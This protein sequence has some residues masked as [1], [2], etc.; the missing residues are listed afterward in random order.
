[1]E[2][3]RQNYISNLHNYLK[4]NEKKV[5]TYS[6]GS[7]IVTLFATQQSICQETRGTWNY[8][9]ELTLS[10]TSFHRITSESCENEY[11]KYIM[12]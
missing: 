9:V 3:E 12:R 6:N 4:K 11:I 7:I 5:K 8:G 2:D 10:R 1:M